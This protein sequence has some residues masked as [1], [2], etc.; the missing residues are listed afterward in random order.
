MAVDKLALY[1]NALTLIGQRTLTGLT[2][3]REPRYL[4]DAAYDLDA[5]AYCLEIVKPV[6][7][8]KTIASNS[9]TPS[10]EHGLDN[11]HTLPADY[12]TVVGV[13]SDE[14]LDEASKISRFIIE[15]NELACEYADIYL[16][17][18]SGDHVTS[19]TNW[20]P[21]F[22][23]VVSSF[24]ASQIC[25][26]L[27]PK[28]VE[29]INSKFLDRVDATIALDKA[30]EPEQRSSGTT[31]TLTNEWRYIYNDALLVMGLEEITTNTDDSNRRTKLDRAV[32]TG[33]VAQL[34]EITGW[35]FATTTTQSNYDPSVE[36]AWG[37]S[38]AHSYPVNM[39]RID[40][41]FYD[42]Y[43][44][45]PLKLYTDEGD[46][47]FTDQDT[48][49]V[50]YIS[51]NFL[52][53]PSNWPAHFKALVAARMATDAAASLRREG[54]DPVRAKEIYDDRES[55]SK[56]IDAMAAPP[57]KLANGSWA[58]SRFRGGYRGRP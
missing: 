29:A 25:F 42:E 44:Q 57:R 58:A 47:I 46:K 32:D 37:F 51:T 14:K 38:R 17:Y 16:R 39:H 54:A 10:S 19:F 12:I 8:R 52:T 27:N 26:K 7:S 9:T 45:Q 11:V 4:L 43:L 6:F 35:T 18:V 2:E 30:R 20:S 41:Y 56:S 23:N 13:Y 28:Q 3:D 33:I 49:Y 48:I 53:N 21:S 15:G 5:I 55:S 50:Q 34:L 1:N 40:G 22:S 24:L 36:P 31:A